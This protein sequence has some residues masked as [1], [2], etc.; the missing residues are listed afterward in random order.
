MLTATTDAQLA[1]ARSRMLAAAVV[2]DDQVRGL[3]QGFADSLRTLAAAE[4]CNRPGSA[5]TRPTCV[6]VEPSGPPRVQRK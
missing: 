4:S 3:C 1:A 6:Q 2:V 5:W